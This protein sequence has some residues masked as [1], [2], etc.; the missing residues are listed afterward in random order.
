MP[1]ANEHTARQADPGKFKTFRRGVP[2]GFPAG[3]SVVYGI[4]DGG[5]TVIQSLRF[6][7]GKWPAEKA[8]AWL[9]DHGFMTG[10]FAAATGK[11]D[12]A[13]KLKRKTDFQGLPVSIEYD[14]GDV[15]PFKNRDGTTGTKVMQAAYGYIPRTTGED[16]EAVDVY[17]G[18]NAGAP[19]AYVVHQ[20]VPD[21]N[22]GF[23]FDEDKVMLG[24]TNAAEAKAMYLAH[25]PD[26]RFHGGMSDVPLAHVRRLVSEAAPAKK[27]FSITVPI[28]KGMGAE[29]QLVF[30]WL[31]V[32]KDKDGN[33]VV[34]HSG[35]TVQIAEIEKAAISYTLLSGAARA[36]HDGPAVG[37]LHT[38]VVFTP[39]LKKVLGIPDGVLPDGWLVGYKIDDP[40]TWERVKSGELQMLSLGGSAVRNEVANAG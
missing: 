37:R 6:D 4:K 19:R 21:G 17:L 25:Y 15:R 14:A 12:L 22:G 1:F 29:Q 11:T 16:G 30:G 20:H 13:K 35:D 10:A 38:S 9:K 32:C 31:Y 40:A 2:D 5:G 3:V 27:A 23:K 33:Q 34:D 8:K 24:F 26:E 7:A 18:G 39:E 28:I 36:M